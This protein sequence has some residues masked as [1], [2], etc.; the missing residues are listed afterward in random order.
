MGMW[1]FTPKGHVLIEADDQG[2]EV[3]VFKNK[4]QVPLLSSKKGL[5]VEQVWVKSVPADDLY[6]ALAF[7][8][9]STSQV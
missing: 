4:G 8:F 6:Q 9:F 5:E 7:K 3:G 2:I 1:I